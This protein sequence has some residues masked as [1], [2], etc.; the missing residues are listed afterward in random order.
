MGAALAAIADDGDL[1]GL[2]EVEIGITIVIDAHRFVSF[3]ASRFAAVRPHSLRMAAAALVR[4]RLRALPRRGRRTVRSRDAASR[5]ISAGVG[6]SASPSRRRICTSRTTRPKKVAKASSASS[7]AIRP[8]VAPRL[9]HRP[10]AAAHGGGPVLQDDGAEVP[11]PPPRRG[12]H[13]A[14]PT[15]SRFSATEVRP[16]DDRQPVAREAFEAF[17]QRRAVEPVRR[18][19]RHAHLCRLPLHRRRQEP[20]AAAEPFVER[21]LGAARAL[22]DRAHRQRLPGIDE[23]AEGGIEHL[24]LTKVSGRPSISASSMSKSPIASRSKYRTL[25][26]GSLARS[27]SRPQEAGAAR[28][29]RR[30]ASDAPRVGCIGSTRASAG[31]ASGR[32]ACAMNSARRQHGDS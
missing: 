4:G 27:S 7:K 25:R 14:S 8:A 24:A 13:S 12:R 3:V 18:H 32:P 15:A 2:D 20:V 30:R 11:M 6:A 1:L 28:P 19:R 22:G 26:Y 16:D 5:A 21:F 9:D 29:A 10:K 23:K 31:G 17:E